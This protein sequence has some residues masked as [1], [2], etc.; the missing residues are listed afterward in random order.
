MS[1]AELSK[2]KPGSIYS[3]NVT[4]VNGDNDKRIYIKTKD[5][6]KIL[7]FEQLDDVVVAV[8]GATSSA[9]ASFTSSASSGSSAS[10]WSS[11]STASTAP[12]APTALTT[13]FAPDTV[14]MID[15]HSAVKGWKEMIYA[16]LII[17]D[18]KESNEI[19]FSKLNSNEIQ[20][21]STFKGNVAI[22]KYGEKG[23]N[24]VIVIETNS[25]ENALK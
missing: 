18:G 3:V 10:S 14:L 22:K 5:N 24:G 4:G 16:P 2:L 25:N 1:V 15:Q 8:G 17:I 19:E 11:A 20:S 12:T 21:I 7:K 13:L 23:K 6:G 9:S